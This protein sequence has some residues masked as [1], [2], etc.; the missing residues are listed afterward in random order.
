MGDHFH[1]L[2]LTLPSSY[3]QTH[4]HPELV[5]SDQPWP[6]QDDTQQ[7]GTAI[8]LPEILPT[9]TFNTS[10]A[11]EV[12]EVLEVG[13]AMLNGGVTHLEVPDPQ[14]VVPGAE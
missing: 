14:P 11:R 9:F 12:S 3:G 2:P 5:L 1:P 13:P 4:T 6:G 7:W 10:T 8:G